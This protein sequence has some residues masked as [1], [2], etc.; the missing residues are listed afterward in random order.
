VLPVYAAQSLQH[1]PCHAAWLT[2]CG[3]LHNATTATR[4]DR[5]DKHDIAAHPL[6]RDGCKYVSYA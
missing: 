5:W 1:C 2:L 6:Q 3:G 4:F